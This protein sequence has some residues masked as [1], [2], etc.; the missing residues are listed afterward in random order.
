M[1]EHS[2]LE[3]Y[4]TEQCLVTELYP[5]SPPLK[6]HRHFSTFKDLLT[7]ILKVKFA[8]RSAIRVFDTSLKIYN[9]CRKPF[10]P[11][12]LCEMVPLQVFGPASARA[13]T[14]HWFT[15]RSDT[16]NLQSNWHNQRLHKSYQ[17]SQAPR[18]LLSWQFHG[19]PPECNLSIS[20]E[21]QIPESRYS[22]LSHRL[23]GLWGLFSKL[24][25]L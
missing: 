15:G 17:H 3:I 21:W 16:I 1:H 22:T 14:G 8:L 12:F 2:D 11:G 24:W 6:P 18:R 7:Y 4:E 13:S 9:F 19:S 10:R 5:L 25:K 23:L 20:R